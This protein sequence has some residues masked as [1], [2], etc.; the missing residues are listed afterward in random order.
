MF[1][2]SVRKH[3]PVWVGVFVSLFSITCL[4]SSPMLEAFAVFAEHRDAILTS[5]QSLT[6]DG[7]QMFP[8]GVAV[9][10][11]ATSDEA[12]TAIAIATASLLTDQ[13]QAL[14]RKICM[15]RNA[16]RDPNQS[17]KVAGVPMQMVHSDRSRSYFIK[18]LSTPEQELKITLSRYC[19]PN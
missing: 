7:F 11:Q 16:N 10:P 1:R 5:D 18:V 3:R 2:G 14:T 19:Q 15:A 12:Q 13:L 17:I 8:L 9:D 6:V 4:A